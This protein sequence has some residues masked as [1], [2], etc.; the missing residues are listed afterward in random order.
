MNMF[1][2]D[3]RR[4]IGSAGLLGVAALTG[5]TAIA[6]SGRG[7]PFFAPGDKRLGVQL[8]ALAPELDADFDGTLAK[9]RKLGI[10]SVETAGFHNRTAAQVRAAFD[11]AALVCSSAHIPATPFGNGPS[12]SGDLDA[13]AR[14]MHTI[15][16]TDVVMPLAL[17]PRPITSLAEFRAMTAA[18]NMDDWHR[19]AAFLNKVARELHKRDL[20]TSYHNHN[21]E[22]VRH[23]GATGFDV[24]LNE[25]DRALVSFEMDAG[26]VAAAGIDPAALLRAHPTRFTQ[27]H[28]KDI[29]AATPG[30]GATEMLPAEVGSGVMHWPAILAAANAAGVRRYYIEQEPPYVGPRI[31]AIAKSTAYLRSVRI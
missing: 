4:L 9:L 22:F 29:K 5:G 15:G 3:R 11:R 16:V 2:M 7:K 24:L 1:K 19:T 17:V 30:N 14:D 26:W 10:R 27:M 31:D 20:A 12:L 23:D 18:L 8:Y 6:A 13:L 28:V 21:F 25:T